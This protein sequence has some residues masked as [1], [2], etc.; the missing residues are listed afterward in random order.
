MDVRVDYG[1]WYDVNDLRSSP[2]VVEAKRLHG[3]SPE[4]VFQCLTY[5]AMVQDI[6]KQHGDKNWVVYGLVSNGL[7]FIFLYLNNDRQWS[8]WTPHSLWDEATTVPH[9]L[10]LVAPDDQEQRVS[11]PP[12]FPVQEGKGGQENYRAVGSY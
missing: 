4:G 3:V 8:K 10:Y 2:L 5:M 1:L 11:K 6:R 12:L 9:D 7:E